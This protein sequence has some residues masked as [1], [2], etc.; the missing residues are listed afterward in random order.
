LKDR[1]RVISVAQ[2]NA[3]PVETPFEVQGSADQ[4]LAV[5]RVADLEDSHLRGIGPGFSFEFP[6][7]CVHTPRCYHA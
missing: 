3:M 5:G 2:C 1:V 4:K 7:S 6:G